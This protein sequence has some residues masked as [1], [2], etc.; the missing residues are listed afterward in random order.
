MSGF[1]EIIV[2]VVIILGILFVPRMMAP[3]R[4]QKS[5]PRLVSPKKI[6]SLQIRMVIAASIIYPALAAA[7]F[8]PWKNDPVPFLYIGLGPVGL[9]WLIGWVL[10]GTRRR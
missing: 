6:L 8:Q 2:I 1:Q 5:A 4:I 10:M 7:Y 9:F 3:R